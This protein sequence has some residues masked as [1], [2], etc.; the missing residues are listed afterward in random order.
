M[1]DRYTV[2]IICSVCV[3]YSYT[4]CTHDYDY[5]LRGKSRYFP[6]KNELMFVCIYIFM[7]GWSAVHMLLNCTFVYMYT[8][9]TLY[10]IISA[11]IQVHAHVCNVYMI[12]VHVHMY[13]CTCTCMHKATVYFS[14]V[15][16]KCTC[17]GTCTWYT[18]F[19]RWVS[20]FE[21]SYSCMMRVHT[22]RPNQTVA[23][24]M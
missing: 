14:H 18:P 3:T 5:R 12:Y 20:F 15:H 16:I 8:N 11:Q 23:M 10:M 19:C 9:C 1:K 6:F 21:L 24:V 13:I 17:N 22:H 2:C 7:C 4:L